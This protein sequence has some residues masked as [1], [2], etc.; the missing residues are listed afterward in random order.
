MHSKKSQ[1][2]VFGK[3][4]KSLQVNA[5]DVVPNYENGITIEFTRDGLAY[6]TLDQQ[7]PALT[8]KNGIEA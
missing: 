6:V 3:I 7:F 5:A 1:S 2:L 4:K 8:K